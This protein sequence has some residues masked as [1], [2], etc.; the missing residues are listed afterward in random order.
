MG[1]GRTNVTELSD[2][3]LLT[4]NG[5]KDVA[6]VDEMAL[7]PIF[8]RGLFVRFDKCVV[9]KGVESGVADGVPRGLVLR[10]V[11]WHEECLFKWI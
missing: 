8:Q 4:L 11:A 9:W 7:F 2:N 1:G 3:T 6:R 5:D 10:A